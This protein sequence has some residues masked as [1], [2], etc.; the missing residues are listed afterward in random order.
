MLPFLFGNK[1]GY[2][3]LDEAGAIQLLE[4]AGYTKGSDGKLQKDGKPLTLKLIAFTGVNP[5]LPLI[6]QVVQS[7]AAQAGITIEIISVEY[8][9]VY[10][11]IIP[12]GIYLQ[13]VI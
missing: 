9:E 7:E 11:A 10:I 12:I 8:P 3:K 4:S 13:R 1:E 6:P 2:Q 5:E